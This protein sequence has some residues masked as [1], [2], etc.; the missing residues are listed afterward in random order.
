[1]PCCD[2]QGILTGRLHTVSVSPLAMIFRQ[3][4]EAAYVPSDV[5]DCV[6]ESLLYVE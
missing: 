5:D 4:F 3:P 6:P 2:L 1:M